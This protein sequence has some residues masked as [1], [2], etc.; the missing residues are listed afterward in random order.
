MKSSLN[1]L[2]MSQSSMSY[3]E[4]Y[5]IIGRGK[6]GWHAQSKACRSSGGTLH[7]QTYDNG[8]IRAGYVD[9]AED[10]C[11][12]YDAE[13]APDGAYIDLVVCGPMLTAG[14]TGVDSFSRSPG[15]TQ[16]LERMLPGFSDGYGALALMALAGL[17]SLDRVE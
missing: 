13:K 9:N 10:G 16:A 11:I 12:V 2:S 5:L 17:S 14:L 4:K 1:K 6:A 7:S 3:N 15:A 8:Q